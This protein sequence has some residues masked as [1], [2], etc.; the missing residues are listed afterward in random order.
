MIVKT[1]LVLVSS[2]CAVGVVWNSLWALEFVKARWKSY[3][4][5]LTCDITCEPLHWSG[6]L[7]DLGEYHA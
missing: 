4:I 6:H 7:I 5:P 2:I 1:D 3:D